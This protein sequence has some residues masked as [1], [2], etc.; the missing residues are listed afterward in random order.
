MGIES[1][2]IRNL[3]AEK[4]REKEKRDSLKKYRKDH[5]DIV[6]Q[7]FNKSLITELNDCDVKV[8]INQTQNNVDLPDGDKFYLTASKN[9]DDILVGYLVRNIGDTTSAIRVFN[10][11]MGMKANIA[12]DRINDGLITFRIPQV[13]VVAKIR[14]VMDSVK[15]KIE[16]S[17][18]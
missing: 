12:R 8:Y 17:Y 2:L 6:V 9:H 13:D 4:A 10:D 5:M 1:I 16:R 11:N 3:R 18:V 7:E 15:P 14:R